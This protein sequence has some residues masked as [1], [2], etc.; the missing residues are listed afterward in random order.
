MQVVVAVAHVCGYPY[1]KLDMAPFCYVCPGPCIVWGVL[2]VWTH[3]ILDPE[4]TTSPR[5]PL[6]ELV[7]IM[8]DSIT[9]NLARELASE[10]KT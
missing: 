4:T 7:I 6:D 9:K 1:I 3:R 5:A 10:S 2:T 8:V